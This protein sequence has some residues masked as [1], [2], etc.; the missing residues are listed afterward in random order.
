MSSGVLVNSY[1]CST[2]RVA[3]NFSS[4]GAFPSFSIGGPVL[5]LIDDCEH[6]LLYLPDTGTASY[7]T[8]ITASLQQ[9]ISGIVQTIEQ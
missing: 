3:D 6:P 1:C 5:H 4:F 9:N 8:A 7:K 2:Y